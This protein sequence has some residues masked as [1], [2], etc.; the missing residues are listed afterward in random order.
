M[1]LDV[2][3]VRIILAVLVVIGFGACLVHA[4]DETE[5]HVLKPHVCAAMLAPAFTVAVTLPPVG[6]RVGL[7][8]SAHLYQ[9]PLHLV[10]PPPKT[11]ALP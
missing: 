2:R 3:W 10:D 4:D 1:R 9:A 7:E 5:D 8:L 11:P 6:P